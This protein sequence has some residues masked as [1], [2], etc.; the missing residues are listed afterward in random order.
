MKGFIDI[1]PDEDILIMIL[2]YPNQSGQSGILFSSHSKSQASGNSGTRPPTLQPVH[3]I[4]VEVGTAN[5]INIHLIV[6]E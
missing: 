4:S 2:P 3:R 6:F 5:S 1:S